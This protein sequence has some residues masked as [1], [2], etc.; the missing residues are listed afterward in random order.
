MPLQGAFVDSLGWAHYRKGELQDAAFYLERARRHVVREDPEI[1]YH[2]GVV[3]GRLGRYSEATD[4]LE[5][6][7]RLAPDWELVQKELRRLGRIL[8]PPV[9]AG[10]RAAPPYTDRP[11]TAA[12]V[13]APHG[14]SS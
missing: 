6:A 2:L 4:A 8:P 7:R 10:S 5:K 11:S 14:R 9:V 12:I 1:L 13:D 3:Y